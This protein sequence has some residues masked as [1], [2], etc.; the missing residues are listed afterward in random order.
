MPPLQNDSPP[1][2][3]SCQH[4]VAAALNEFL[5]HRF[6]LAEPVVTHPQHR[7]LVVGPGFDLYMRMPAARMSSWPGA[8]LVIARIAFDEERAGHGRALL[9]CLVDC[10][11]EA[12]FDHLG[13]EQTHD[14][15][16]IR[17]FVSAHGFR[18]AWPDRERPLDNW[19]A[20]VEV[21]RAHLSSNHARRTAR[22]PCPAAHGGAPRERGD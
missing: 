1:I 12:G 13:I 9:Q 19:V 10:A 4:V 5:Q 16:N 14:G 2:A 18:P 7:M 11:D 17:G 6:G 8:T 21:V 3:Q 20:P 15:E 22:R